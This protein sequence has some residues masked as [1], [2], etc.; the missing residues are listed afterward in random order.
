MMK[1]FFITLLF[2]MTSFSTLA[3]KIAKASE[4]DK[5]FITHEKFVMLS[6]EDRREVVIKLMEYMVSSEAQTKFREVV[7]NGTE[8]E[9]A[10]WRKVVQV[11]GDFFI[12]SAE[13]QDPYSKYSSNYIKMINGNT[14]GTD[15]RCIYAGWISKTK[16]PDGICT[17]PK[18][19]KNKH[20]SNL[21]SYDNKCPTVK[22]REQISCNPVIF[23]FESGS[24]QFCVDSYPAAHNSSLACM[25]LALSKGNPEARLDAIAEN[26]AKNPEVFHTVMEFIFYTCACDPA[27]KGDQ[28]AINEKYHKYMRP[29]RTC[30]GLLNQMKQVLNR[31]K[32][33]P[34]KDEENF[35]VMVKFLNGI[36]TKVGAYD[37]EAEANKIAEDRK[38]ASEKNQTF[39][40]EYGK[41]IDE[42]YSKDPK[43]QAFCKSYLSPDDKSDT[44]PI[45]PVTP[46]KDKD[47]DGDKN[48]SKA[49]KIV[50]EPNKPAEAAKT[51]VA[52]T[53]VKTEEKDKEGKKPEENKSSEQTKEE[54]KAVEYICKKVISEAGKEDSIEEIPGLITSNDQLKDQ[55]S[56]DLV[57]EGGLPGEGT[58]EKDEEGNT[59]PAGDDG[60]VTA[61]IT[62][63]STPE[64][65]TLT[66]AVKGT[67]AAGA[68]EDVTEG[69][70]FK[71]Y[72]KSDKAELTGD[73][74]S[75]QPRG[76]EKYEVCAEVTPPEGKTIANKEVCGEVPAAEINA[77]ANQ[78]NGQ[79]NMQRPQR[80]KSIHINFGIR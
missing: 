31:T 56:G 54:T 32:C 7:K 2:L 77:P 73:S 42:V 6:T 18:N 1:H 67:D 74:S 65:T 5:T 15:F 3:V 37:L 48:Q 9:K 66:I 62:T 70:K 61:T 23:G 8:E 20:G 64:K 11:I 63:S 50:C 60:A 41:A 44:T 47:K 68:E 52:T 40:D 4:Y 25:K 71:W 76:T 43:T 59:T 78:G 10:K 46:D 49:C 80:Q 34:L 53:D 39:D 26:L 21:V 16:L 75:E 30:Y 27:L 58:T 35:Q 79:G 57:C 33:E 29:H 28:V 19:V 51:E 22:G 36:Q 14:V 72:K 13:A 45:D 55:K 12:S 24:K 38:V 17:H 69:S